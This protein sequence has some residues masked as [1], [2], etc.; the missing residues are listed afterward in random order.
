ME[1]NDLSPNGE[2]DLERA[3]SISPLKFASTRVVRGRPSAGHVF[4]PAVHTRPL[5]TQKR[6]SNDRR[7]RDA[8]ALGA[9]VTF[10]FSP[11]RPWRACLPARAGA[12]R[13]RLR[14][15][16]WRSA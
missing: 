4:G 1:K 16:F 2:R 13:L 8:L 12:T 5:E 3:D 10:S 15:A 7:W 6:R 11:R 14:P 9:N